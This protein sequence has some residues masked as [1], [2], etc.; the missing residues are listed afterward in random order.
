MEF[1]PIKSARFF[2]SVFLFAI[3]LSFVTACKSSVS[4]IEPMVK[5]IESKYILKPFRL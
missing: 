4:T 2:S 1:Q 5:K 3:A